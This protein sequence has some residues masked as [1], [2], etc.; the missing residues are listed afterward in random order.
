M[1]VNKLIINSLNKFNLP[2]TYIKYSGSQPSYLTFFLVNNY[3]DDYSDNNGEIDVYS[4]QIDLWSKE[5]T[6]TL[7]EEIKKELKKTF[8][9]VTF[10]DLYED[11]TS[12]Y[13]TAFRCYYYEESEE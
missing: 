7:K 6:T 5:D 4:I 1:N 13:H 3:D 11:E 8:R 2:T 12:T 9:D 10:Q